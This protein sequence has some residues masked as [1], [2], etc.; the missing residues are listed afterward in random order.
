MYTHP[1]LIPYLYSSTS[2][3]NPYSSISIA[4]TYSSHLHPPPPHLHPHL[5]PLHLHS[6]L[7]T[8][9]PPPALH[10][11][12]VLHKHT[13]RIPRETPSATLPSIRFQPFPDSAPQPNIDDGWMRRAHTALTHGSLIE[14]STYETSPHCPLPLS[15]VGHQATSNPSP[16]S[17][18]RLQITS[19]KPNPD[20]HNNTIHSPSI[21]TPPQ[22]TLP[23][24]LPSLDPRT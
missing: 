23:L 18:H 16:L 17:S 4:N 7:I 22:P 12:R 21:Q 24:S 3:A 9:L 1:I 2:I 13:H 11:P 8:P 5:I 20:L 14:H 19:H 10:S 15:H 6:P